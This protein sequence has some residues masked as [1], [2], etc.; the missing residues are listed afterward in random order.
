MIFQ[1]KQLISTLPIS[2][3]NRI[4]HLAY[5][6]RTQLWWSYPS[7]NSNEFFAKQNEKGEKWIVS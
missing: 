4:G 2:K 1:G 3:D 5:P 6:N 7:C